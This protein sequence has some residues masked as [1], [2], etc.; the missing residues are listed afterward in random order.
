MLSSL[1][2]SHAT[3]PPLRTLQSRPNNRIAGL[4]HLW[5]EST[6]NFGTSRQTRLS[7]HPFQT[8]DLDSYAHLPIYMYG[9]LNRPESIRILVLLPSKDFSAPLEGDLIH[10]DRQTMLWQ[11]GSEGPKHYEA[12]SYCWGTPEFSNILLCNGRTSI[13]KISPNVDTMLRHLRNMQEQRYLWIDAI[14]LNQA[15]NDEKSVQ[16]KIMGDIFRYAK[17]VH[18]WLGEADDRVPLVLDCFRALALLKKTQSPFSEVKKLL[19][20]FF[21]MDGDIEI[22][23]FLAR[24]WFRRR[25]VLQEAALGHDI[26]VH[27]GQTNLGWTWLVDG[28]DALRAATEDGLRL[29]S[30]SI[31]SIENVCTI[32]RG[33]Q[34]ILDLLWDFHSAQCSDPRD[35]LFGLLGLTKDVKYGPPEDEESRGNGSFNRYDPYKNRN[36]IVSLLSEKRTPG[37]KIHVSV[38]YTPDWVETYTRFAQACVT[39]GHIETI[40]QHAVSFGSLA[41]E[42]PDWSS[43]V[44]KWSASRSLRRPFIAEYPTYD[45]VPL[46]LTLHRQS[47]RIKLSGYVLGPISLTLDLNTN[48]QD[49]PRTR[50]NSII[51]EIRSTWPRLPGDVFLELKVGEHLARLIATIVLDR[52]L[53]LDDQETRQEIAL[54]F[55]STDNIQIDVSQYDKYIPRLVHALISLYLDGRMQLGSQDLLIHHGKD[56]WIDPQRFPILERQ[57]QNILNH[58]QLFCIG[59]YV[60]FFGMGPPQTRSGDYVLK[61]PRGQSQAAANSPSSAAF[62]LRPVGL[63]GY[64]LLGF[65]RVEKS[66]S[67]AYPLHTEIISII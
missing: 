42:R 51:D 57:V 11:K 5:K 4:I 1:S 10:S 45:I 35:R 3:W 2:L 32:G 54:I 23:R 16:V 24:P 63:G 53:V 13:V 20:P 44:P 43:W 59:K 47:P 19:V 67:N 58:Q 14:C 39:A 25:W 31:G 36:R 34:S 38:D 62:V 49:S 46:E 50:I 61:L 64:Q 26:T 55:G 30:E 28:I 18:I 33:P 27:C 17:K 56:Q 12:V 21:D 41:Q 8:S 37:A 6:L 48:P 15:D 29:N 52:Q 65:C 60:D 66:P 7:E 9:P 40:F 22:S